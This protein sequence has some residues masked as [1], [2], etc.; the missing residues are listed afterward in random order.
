MPRRNPSC[1]GQ[2]SSDYA[3]TRQNSS[4]PSAN[5]NVSGE[6]QEFKT[7][8]DSGNRRKRGRIFKL[9]IIGDV[10]YGKY[11]FPPTC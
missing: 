6:Q 3:Q 1:I 9:D 11:L 4:P 8:M 5:G 7:N 2:V 10:R